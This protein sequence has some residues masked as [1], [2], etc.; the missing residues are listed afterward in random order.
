MDQAKRIITKFGGRAKMAR[1][2]AE[3]RF[4]YERL[5]KIEIKGVFPAEDYPHLLELGVKLGVEIT[6]YDFI[7]HLRDPRAA[8]IESAAIGAR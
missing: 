2:A 4:T 1:D 8:N 7:A 3:S 5:R 6:P